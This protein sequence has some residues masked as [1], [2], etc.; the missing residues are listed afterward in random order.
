[1]IKKISVIGMLLS[2]L[3]IFVLA[4]LDI[5]NINEKKP[6]NYYI[7]NTYKETGSKNYVT[8]IYLDYRLFDSIFEAS[9]LLIAVAGI[10]FISKEES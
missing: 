5:F 6:E 9:T 7:K 10:V 2:L 4:T 3:Y 1:M 8:G